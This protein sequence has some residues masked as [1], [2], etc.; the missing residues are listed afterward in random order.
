MR[1]NNKI[2][3]PVTKIFFKLPLKIQWV[4]IKVVFSLL[5]ED[6]VFNL[7]HFP[8]TSR[9]WSCWTQLWRPVRQ[10]Q[11]QPRESSHWDT[12]W[13]STSSS[14]NFLHGKISILIVPIAQRPYC[15]PLG[16]AAILYSSW[17]RQP[18]FIPRGSAAILCPS[19][20]GSHIV[21]LVALQPY[22]FLTWFGSHIVSLLVRQPYCIPCGS[23][24]ILHLSWFRQ[25]YWIPHG[26]GTAAILYPSWFRQP[27]CFPPCSATIC[28]VS[29]L[30]LWQ[31]KLFPEWKTA[32]MFL[33]GNGSRSVYCMVEQPSCF[34]CYGWPSSRL[35]CIATAT[36]SKRRL[37]VLFPFHFAFLRIDYWLF[38]ISGKRE[39]KK[40]HWY[41]FSSK[42]GG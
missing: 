9:I 23:A 19:W 20:Y 41:T 32:R 25:P 40:A 39:V 18:Y 27:Y 28:I 38:F 5:S 4:L 31:C 21:S 26:F 33:A 24:A 11:R 22:C 17:F 34:L 3:L 8:F 30:E 14:S 42:Q 12:Y 13:P 2:L 29:Y 10:L 35:L 16:A 15:F 7:D 6:E 37:K 36:R 1:S